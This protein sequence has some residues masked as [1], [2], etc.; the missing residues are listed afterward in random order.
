MQQLEQLGVPR[1][2]LRRHRHLRR[3]DP[4]GDPQRPGQS[5]FHIGPA[6]DLPIFDGLDVQLRAARERRLRRLLRPRRRRDRDAGGLSRACSSRCASASCSWSAPIPTSWS[7]AATSW[8]I[9]PARSPISTARW[10]ARCSTPASRIAPIYDAGA[11]ASVQRRR[12]RASACW[13]S[14]I[15]CAPISRARTPSASIACS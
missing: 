8:S 10:A 13:R 12:R 11:G 3:R 2:D 6:R 15:R 4:R 5:V 14:A 1:D 9:A 7:S